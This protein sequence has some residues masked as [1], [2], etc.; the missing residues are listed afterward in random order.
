LG[1]SLIVVE[2]AF[3]RDYRRLGLSTVGTVEYS[4]GGECVG[5][6]GSL[7]TGWERIGGEGEEGGKSG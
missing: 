1:A 7:M 5:G 4:V 3:V 2:G 6:R